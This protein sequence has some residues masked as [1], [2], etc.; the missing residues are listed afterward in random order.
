MK[1]AA[2]RIPADRPLSELG[3]DS[4]IGV[5]LQSAL[6]QA[7]GVQISLL[8]LSKGAS[9]TDLARVV[10]KRFDLDGGAGGDRLA[11]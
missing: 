10:L 9:V 2:D 3:I 7:Y 1:M 11:A 5:E 6:G 4:L 8:Q